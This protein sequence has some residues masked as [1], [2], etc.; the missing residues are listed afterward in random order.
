M[1]LSRAP[2]SL[3]I[4]CSVMG[5]VP[6]VAASDPAIPRPMTEIEA[7]A[8]A[9]VTTKDKPEDA[10]A[11]FDAFTKWLGMSLLCPEGACGSIVSAKWTSANLDLDEDDEKVLAITTAGAGTCAPAHVEAIVFDATKDGWAAVGH[12]SVRLAA[13]TGPTTE[14]VAASVH[15]SKVK[16]LIVRVDGRCDGGERAQELRVLTLEHGRLEEIAASADFVG[17]GLVAHALEGAPPAKLVLTDA[18]GKK[19]LFFDEAAFA[20][21]A[22]PPYDVALKASVSKDDDETLGTKQ[23]AAPLGPSV[24]L[25]CGLEGKAKVQVVVQKGRATGLS[26]SV[27]PAHPSFVRCM[28]KHVAAASW[29]SVPGATGCTR[30]Y[31]AK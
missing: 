31:A 13:A 28:R 3:A 14:V 9:L 23:C 27:T 1:P 2:L 19:P 30:T 8:K 29:P 18:N 12:A 11:R 4:V 17:T 26:V 20:Y 16:D 15:A 5:S 10:A 24:A 21:D 22:L 25:D 7:R 6:L